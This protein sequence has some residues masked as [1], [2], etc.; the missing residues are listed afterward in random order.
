MRKVMTLCLVHEHPKI[1]LGLKKK[2][3]GEGKWNGFGGKVEENETVEEAAAREFFEETGLTADN[4]EKFGF[5][6]LI[7]EADYI[8][9][10]HLFK[11]NGYS[12]ELVES[13]EMK[14]QWFH[15]DDI[16]FDEMWS[17]DK[18]WLPLLLDGKKFR[19]KFIFGEQGKIL[20]HFLEEV[21]EI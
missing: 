19:G 4:V 14:P 7:N 18:H 11:V 16:P 17:D 21:E 13:D 2:G 8:V 9:E 5:L 3:F 15:V 6:E 1:L 20:E 10:M 12:G